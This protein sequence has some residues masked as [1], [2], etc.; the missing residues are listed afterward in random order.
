[1]TGKELRLGSINGSHGIKGWVKVFSY[2]DPMEAIFDYSPWILKKGREIKEVKVSKGQVSGKRLIAQL[3][4]VDSRN[5]ANALIGYEIHIAQDALPG[6]EEGEYYW[7]QLEGLKVRDEKGTVF[8]QVDHLLETGA[9]DVMVVK[10]TEDSVD[11]QE[12]LIPFVYNEIV[13]DVD[14]AT[15]EIVVDWQVDY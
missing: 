11:D 4:E 6:L 3:E 13:I 1:M 15:R 2:T 14:Q 9:N 8:G 7:F 12:R 5:A 10:P